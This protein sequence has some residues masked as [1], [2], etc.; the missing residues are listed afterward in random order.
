M[1]FWKCAF[2]I[3]LSAYF[4]LFWTGVDWSL[5]SR[6]KRMLDLILGLFSKGFF[7]KNKNTHDFNMIQYRLLLVCLV[8]IYR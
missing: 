7:T 5:F 8:P 6:F 1:I 2:F 4:K 3:S